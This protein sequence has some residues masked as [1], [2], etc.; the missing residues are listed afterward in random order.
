MTGLTPQGL[1]RKKW[2]QFK[3]MVRDYTI[4]FWICIGFGILFLLTAVSLFVAV[5]LFLE[6]RI[7]AGV[8]GAFLV[9]VVGVGLIWAALHARKQPWVE[10][11]QTEATKKGFSATSAG[12]HPYA[13]DRD[14]EAGP[15]KAPQDGEA[16]SPAGAG[17]PEQSQE[18]G[19]AQE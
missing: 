12:R 1:R 3:K 10:E 9:A 4:L 2:E 14:P 11:T 5:I 17:P 18:P 7:E 6:D 15:M 19:P 13:G 8:L 16:V